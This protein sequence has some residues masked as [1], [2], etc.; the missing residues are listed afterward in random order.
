MAAPLAQRVA[1]VTGGGS[2]IGRASAHAFAREGAAVVVVDID[3]GAAEET[4]V[5]VCRA[6][7]QAI[8]VEADVSVERDVARVIEVVLQVYGR[9]DCAHNN[10][11]IQGDQDLT[12]ECSECNWDRVIAVNLKG[13]WLS[14]KHEV[15]AM[16]R[17]GGGAI[18][19]TASAFGIV[20]AAY[21][22]PAYIASKH[23]I[24][25][26]TRAA[27][28]E[29]ARMGL[30]INAVCPALTRTPM[31]APYLAASPQAEAAA[32][33]KHPI[34]RIAMPEEIAELVVWLSSDAASFITGAALPIDGGLTAQ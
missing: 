9:L 3:A 24:V 26:L 29:Y 7:G 22:L 13:C 15:P 34:G 23:A 2:G 20:G 12:A 27:A 31:I 4:V 21:G 1:L 17:H 33:A 8:H 32:N 11:G 10:A 19:N 18:V 14:M 25:G 16:L 28:L 30:R 5:S 6:G